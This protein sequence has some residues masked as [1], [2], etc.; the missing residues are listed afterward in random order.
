M[1]AMMD[2]VK[3]I[4]D[5]GETLEN[6]RFMGKDTLLNGFCMFSTKDGKAVLANTDHIFAILEVVE[7]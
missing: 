1:L 5:S 3:I 4:M 2:D 6:V 7:K